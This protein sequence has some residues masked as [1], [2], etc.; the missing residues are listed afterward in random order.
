MDMLKCAKSSALAFIFL[1][2]ACTIS[3]AQGLS[4][5]RSLNNTKWGYQKVS[6]PVRAG[7][8]SQR[9]ELRA[10]DCGTDAY[11]S[12]C[13][14]GSERSEVK[15][16]KDWGPNETMWIGGSVYIPKDFRFNPDTTHILQI[17]TPSDGITGPNPQ[18]F[19]LT[20]ADGRFVVTLGWIDADGNQHLDRV[21]LGSPKQLLGKWTDFV[22]GIGPKAGNGVV[23]YQDGRLVLNEA[24]RYKKPKRYYLKY[25]IYRST[26]SMTNILF[27]DEIRIGKSRAKVEVDEARP[28][29]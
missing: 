2:A 15:S 21:S 13:D 9:F 16:R 10:G 18:P 1:I 29:D 11:G 23:V 27:W 24:I 20:V 19:S 5:E 3:I 8:I 14:R 26:S 25:G 12:D 28:V 4:V 22:I 6:D 17:K 7:K